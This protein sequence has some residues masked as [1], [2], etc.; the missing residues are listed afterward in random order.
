LGELEGRLSCLVELVEDAIDKVGV[1]RIESIERAATDRLDDELAKQWRDAHHLEFGAHRVQSGPEVER[2]DGDP[3]VHL[4]PDR[5]AV[6]HPEG[7]IGWDNPDAELRLH[8]HHSRDGVDQ[9]V[10]AGR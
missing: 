4:D 10:P 2:T 9:L 3:A 6:G 8:A 5:V 1:V 7:A